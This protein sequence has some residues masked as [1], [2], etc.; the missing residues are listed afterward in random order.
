MSRVFPSL[1]GVATFEPTAILTQIIAILVG[2]IKGIASGIGEGLSTLAT[3]IFLD[4]T[5]ETAT[6]SVFG[7]VVAIF[8][9]ISLAV[10]LCR[11]VVRWI[12]SLGGSRV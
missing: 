4:T 10:G 3:S 5:G 8:A 12:S 11:L 7:M 1:L 2:G 6:L 9:G